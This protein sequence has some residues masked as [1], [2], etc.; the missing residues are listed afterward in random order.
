MQSSNTISS[1][2]SVTDTLTQNIGSN[3]IDRDGLDMSWGVFCLSCVTTFMWFTKSRDPLKEPNDPCFPQK[4]YT[5]TTE[6]SLTSE[7]TRKGKPL[8]VLNS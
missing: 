5:V 1:V 3:L 8:S 4:L 2:V 7:F 6:V